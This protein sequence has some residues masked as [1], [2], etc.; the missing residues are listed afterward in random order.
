[1]RKKHQ[2]F[3]M[4]WSWK[5]R[6]TSFRWKP[7]IVIFDG[8]PLRTTTTHTLHT[9]F[10]HFLSPSTL[11]TSSAHLTQ[12][13]PLRCRCRSPAWANRCRRALTTSKIQSCDGCWPHRWS[14]CPC[15]CAWYALRNSRH[16][17]SEATKKSHCQHLWEKNCLLEKNSSW[18]RGQSRKSQRNHFKS[19]VTFFR[20]VFF[21]PTFWCVAFLFCG[22]VCYFFVIFS[23]WELRPPCLELW[24][25]RVPEKKHWEKS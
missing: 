1:M 16:P 13:V 11:T 14:A 17:S 10:N 3:I 9:V 4:S 24:D 19:S 25:H 12:P 22:L 15:P 20:L 6:N 23:C 8:H 18:I 2:V 5:E 21:H 7:Q